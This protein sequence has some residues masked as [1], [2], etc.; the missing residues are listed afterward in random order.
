MHVLLLK[1]ATVQTVAI[2]RNV[3]KLPDFC[4]IGLTLHRRR[5]MCESGVA[6]NV[7]AIFKS[8]QSSA[9]C[10]GKRPAPPTVASAL[11]LRRPPLCV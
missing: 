2:K 3:T 10:S 11:H 6:T 5:R 4:Q 8:S 9:P 1:A 7:G